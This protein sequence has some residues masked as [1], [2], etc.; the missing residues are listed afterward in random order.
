MFCQTFIPMGSKCSFS[1]YL[2]NDCDH[3]CSMYW[4]FKIDKEEENF[5]LKIYNLGV[6]DTENE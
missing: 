2:L 6:E 5:P 3:N 4:G 1:N